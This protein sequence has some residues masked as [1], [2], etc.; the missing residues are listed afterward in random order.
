VSIGIPNLRDVIFQ[1]LFTQSRCTDT[2]HVGLPLF[3]LIAHHGL[4]GV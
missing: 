1:S 3:S 4:L 2:V